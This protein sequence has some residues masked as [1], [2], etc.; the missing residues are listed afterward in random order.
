MHAL[1]H[2]M[3]DAI[4]EEEHAIIV[5]S[6]TSSTNSSPIQTT[7]TTIFET[8]VPATCHWRRVLRSRPAMTGTPHRDSRD[9]VPRELET[10]WRLTKRGKVVRCVLWS[11][12]AGWELKVAEPTSC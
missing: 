4:T 8:R 11:H 3:L 1:D 12:W 5:S 6:G 9:H 7:W 10:L 2:G